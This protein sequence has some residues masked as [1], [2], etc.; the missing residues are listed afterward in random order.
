MGKW[1]A[2]EVLDGALAIVVGANRAVALGSQPTT[3]AAAWS[4]RLAEATL[5]AGDFS[6][7]PGDS[8]GRKVTIAAKAGADVLV[9][10]SATHVALLDTTGGRLLYVTTCPDQPLAMGGTVN[11]E[12]WSVEI[13]APV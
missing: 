6:V 8:S 2:E 11:F 4:G 13:G 9:P 7:G 3:F 10:G 1:V 12:S 5:T